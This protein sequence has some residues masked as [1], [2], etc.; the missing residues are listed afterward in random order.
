MFQRKETDSDND[1][2]EEDSH[3][4]KSNEEV[5][6]EFKLMTTELGVQFTEFDPD[7]VQSALPVKQ[8][9]QD[10]NEDEVSL[11]DD[12]LDNCSWEDVLPLPKQVDSVGDLNLFFRDFY[13]KERMTCLASSTVSNLFCV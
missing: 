5:E 12:Q 3:N 2:S 13:N 6:R 9:K 11:Y 8:D 1:S 4:E 10:K 7:Q